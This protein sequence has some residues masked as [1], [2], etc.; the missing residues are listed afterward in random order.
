MKKLA[1]FLVSVFV[2]SGIAFADNDKPIQIGQLPTKAQTFLSTYFKSSKVALAK[3]ETDLFSKSYDVIFTTGVAT[4]R[5][6]AARSTEFLQ[7]LFL[8]G[9]RATC[10]ATIPTPGS[11]LSSVTAATMK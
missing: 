4:G 9:S 7:R 1:L 10:R 5:K 3:Q 11:C 6:L 2:M 8:R